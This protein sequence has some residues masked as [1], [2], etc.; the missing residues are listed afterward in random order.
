MRLIDVILSETDTTVSEE[1]IID[2]SCPSNYGPKY[3]KY[4]KG[5]GDRTCRECWEQEVNADGK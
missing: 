4:E 5:C 3:D 1:Y 2:L